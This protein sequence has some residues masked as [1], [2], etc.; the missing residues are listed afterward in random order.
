MSDEEQAFLNGIV[1]QPDDILRRLV[2]ADWLDENGQERRAEFI[3]WQCESDEPYKLSGRILFAA[4]IRQPVNLIDLLTDPRWQPWG[5][6]WRGP[7]GVLRI[8]RSMLAVTNQS[9]TA[10]VFWANGLPVG[11]SAKLATFTK[12]V[13][14]ALMFLPIRF[15]NVTDDPGIDNW[16]GDPNL[17]ALAMNPLNYRHPSDP[18]HFAGQ[19]FPGMHPKWVVDQWHGLTA[20]HKTGAKA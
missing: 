8:S 20:K 3:R 19:S 17:T 11:I 1:D 12:K 5:E 18:I 2:F 7:D 13:N 6:R 14:R 15:I 9:E 10:W 16:L 4:K